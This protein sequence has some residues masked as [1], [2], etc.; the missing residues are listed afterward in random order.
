[1]LPPTLK[2][3]PATGVHDFAAQVI[4]NH[5]EQVSHR[6]CPVSAEFLPLGRFAVCDMKQ[7]VGLH[8]KKAPDKAEDEYH[9]K[10]AH[11]PHAAELLGKVEE[12]AHLALSP[13][14]N[15]FKAMIFL[16]EV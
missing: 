7:T 11:A 3:K 15:C 9:A 16:R 6:Y 10:P 4:I 13:N 12:T 5:P 1:M 2:N 14:P 8:V